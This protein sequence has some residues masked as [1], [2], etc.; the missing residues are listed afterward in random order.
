MYSVVLV[1]G[2]Q[3]SASALRTHM[4]LFI[5]FRALSSALRN[6]HLYNDDSPRCVSRGD[7]FSELTVSTLKLFKYLKM[8]SSLPSQPHPIQSATS[9]LLQWPRSI[10]ISC[11]M[12]SGPSTLWD[13]SLGCWLAC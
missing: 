8:A 7:L 9:S 11:L 2:V 1:S 10:S 3:Q 4:S 13:A 12:I 5:A 6:C